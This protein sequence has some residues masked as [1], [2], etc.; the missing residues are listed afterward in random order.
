MQHHGFNIACVIRKA[1]GD[2]PSCCECVNLRKAIRPKSLCEL[3]AEL[4]ARRHDNLY[5]A[6]ECK[7]DNC[8]CVCIKRYVVVRYE[9]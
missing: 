7:S 8:M 4:Y 6:S 2:Q 9:I 3:F 5:G 1:Y